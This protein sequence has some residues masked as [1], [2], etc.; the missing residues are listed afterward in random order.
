MAQIVLCLLL[1]S[2]KYSYDLRST[3]IKLDVVELLCDTRKHTGVETVLRL[4]GAAVAIHVLP[5]P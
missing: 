5:E 1:G 4:F 3:V 2:V